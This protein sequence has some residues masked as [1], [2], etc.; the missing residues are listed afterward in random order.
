MRPLLT[1]LAAV[2]LVHVTAAQHNPD[3]DP[4]L[5]ASL[6]ADDWGMRSYTLAILRTGPATGL[7][8]AVT[9]SCFRGHLDNIGRLVESG[10]MVVAGPLGRND[11][12]YRGLFI[13]TATDTAQVRTLLRTDPA[14]AAGLL[15]ADLYP[16]Y[17][18]A[19]L[20]TYLEQADKVWKV[21]P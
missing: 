3:H 12:G 8:K 14:V 10:D 7:E 13:F 21:K 4:A 9:D 1:L 20:P 17:G 15:A 2:G 19:A 11:K 18:S 16:W 6:G 5:A